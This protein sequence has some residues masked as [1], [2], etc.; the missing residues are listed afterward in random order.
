MIF[1]IQ[2]NKYRCINNKN[3]QTSP[4]KNTNHEMSE[5]Y[6][7]TELHGIKKP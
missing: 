6:K 2:V 3:M 4:W 5:S 7:T 1:T